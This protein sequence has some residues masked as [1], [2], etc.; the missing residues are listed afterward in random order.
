MILVL[1]LWEEL[2]MNFTI[3]KSTLATMT[4]LLA[5][6]REKELFSGGWYFVEITQ[7]NRI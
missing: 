6:L 2:F 7:G 4:K 5:V 1:L 3:K